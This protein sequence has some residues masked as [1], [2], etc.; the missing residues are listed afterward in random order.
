M[1]LVPWIPVSE[2][3]PAERDVVI[4]S[5]HCVAIDEPPHVYPEGYRT[6]A[7]WREGDTWFA[8]LPFKMG[9][10][11]QGF[12]AEMGDVRAVDFWLTLP[13]EHPQHG[14]VRGGY[15]A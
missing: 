7:G 11:E 2:Q 9:S 10:S 1:T 4:V 6:F 5:Q 15:P 13:N 12:V 14:A 3:L 8:Y